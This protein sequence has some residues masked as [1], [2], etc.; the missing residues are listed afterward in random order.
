[1]D[2]R[3]TQTLQGQSFQA[4][5]GTADAVFQNLSLLRWYRPDLVAAFAAD[6]PLVTGLN[7]SIREFQ[8]NCRCP[9]PMTIDPTR[10][11]V[12][13]DGYMFER[14]TLEN[15]RRPSSAFP[16]CGGASTATPADDDKDQPRAHTD[17]K[18]DGHSFPVDLELGDQAYNR[19]FK[20]VP[21]P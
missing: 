20:R 14:R 1:M 17:R 6:G 10:A 21:K 12:F 2:G 8:E 19:A 11:Y 16:Y 5:K 15:L 7:D 4:F 3:N 18:R 9:T 13:M